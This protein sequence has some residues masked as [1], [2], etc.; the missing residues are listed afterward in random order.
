MEVR[1]LTVCELLSS[2]DDDYD[3]DDYCDDE[4]A[5]NYNEIF[6]PLFY[7]LFAEHFSLITC[8]G[9]GSCS[10]WVKVNKS[11]STFSIT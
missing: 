10:W 5:I 6:L 8:C 3:V 9:G 2:R 1:R 11:F 7:S 4:S